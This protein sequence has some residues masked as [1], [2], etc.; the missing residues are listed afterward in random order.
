MWPGP[1]VRPSV[2]STASRHWP[3]D[4]GD[5]R[6][7]A[8]GSSVQVFYDLESGSVTRMSRELVEAI[9]TFEGRELPRRPGR[10]SA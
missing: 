8:D 10:V 6:V 3:S 4:L 5:A 9:T 2:S 7:V 1:A